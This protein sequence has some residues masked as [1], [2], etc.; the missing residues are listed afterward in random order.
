MSR[1][2]PP[3][4]INLSIPLSP[5]KLKTQRTQGASGGT[6]PYHCSNRPQ[7]LPLAT[8]ALESAS[9]LVFKGVRPTSP[10]QASQHASLCMITSR[11]SFMLL[12]PALQ[13]KMEATKIKVYKTKCV[14]AGF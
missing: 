4:N 12:L 9:D 3:V 7:D 10:L 14:R 8:A 13:A 5:V 6:Y 11:E 2:K 1:F